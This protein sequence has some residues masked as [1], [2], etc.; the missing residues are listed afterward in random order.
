MAYG[1]AEDQP[2]SVGSKVFDKAKDI[3]KMFAR[4]ILKEIAKKILKILM[5]L[6]LQLIAK[7]IVAL[8][9][10]IGVPAL[11]F[12]G[13][14]LLIGGGIIYASI[15]FGW[16][17]GDSTGQQAQQLI[18]SYQTAI[19][20]T[21]DLPEYRPPMLVVQAI[22]NIRITKNGLDNTEID[23]SI[24]NLL[25]PDLTYRN[26]T[27]STTTT[28]TV[29]E[30]VTIDDGD[31]KSHEEEHSRTESST[32]YD[33][34]SLLVK[35]HAWN[36]V[37]T[38]T[39]HQESNSTSDGDSTITKTYW[40]RDA[41]PCYAPS[42]TTTS[43]GNGSD[44]T[45]SDLPTGKT[46]PLFL[47]Y[48][49]AASEEERVSGVP[50]S[51]TLAQMVQESGFAL[52]ELAT[53]YYN[54]F[55]IKAQKGDGWTGPTV[56][57]KTTEQDRNGNVQVITAQFRVYSNAIEGFHGHSLFLLQNGR[58]QPVLAL[59][60]PYAFANGLQAVGYA[61]DIHYAY[62]L[63]SLMH[64]YNLLQYDLDKGIDPSTG[65]P[66]DDIN[67]T[68]PI[69]DISGGISSGCGTP[70]FTKFDAALKKLNFVSDDVSMVMLI[71]NEN[72]SSKSML[73]NYNGEFQDAYKTMNAKDIILSFI[74]PSQPPRLN[75]T[76][77]HVN[78]R[79][80]KLFAWNG[81]IG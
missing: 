29:R 65:K 14:A 34:V 64:E 50:A 56:D 61:T 55:G 23:P 18:N 70:D 66:Y 49:P 62:Q 1:D 74:S 16:L 46:H 9:A 60:N 63:R 58:Y 37:E 11:I 80:L 26:F 6:I 8:L 68:G 67:Y 27:N 40:V 35:A 32:T 51:V 7:A 78:S 81:V 76:H 20:K 24:A 33:T 79:P 57:Y 25:R 52:S 39:Y 22:D 36:R 53:K 19:S 77:M 73:S 28:T 30:T 15:S 21:S 38:I 45:V 41:A 69:G 3:G 13:L 48:G 12:I 2:Q 75:D 31:G 59:K 17:S 47:L 5:K 44:G 54:F 4:K 10:Y 43:G 72:D 71:I 42:G